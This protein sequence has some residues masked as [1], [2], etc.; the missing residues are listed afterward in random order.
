MSV[1]TRRDRMLAPLLLLVAGCAGAGET[2]DRAASVAPDRTAVAEQFLRGLYGGEPVVVD[3]L[4]APDIVV[5]YPIF[6]KVAATFRVDYNHIDKMYWHT[7]NNDYRKP[8]D[9]GRIRMG[10]RGEKWNLMFYMNNMTDQRWAE[11][12]TAGEYGGSASDFL[13]P[14]KPRHWGINYS[15]RL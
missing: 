12:F 3:V 9:I 10:L 5:S 7:N 14:N 1:G 15:R 8:L 11:E 4:A 2:G 13:H 6:E